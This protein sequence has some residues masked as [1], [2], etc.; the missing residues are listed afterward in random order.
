LYY[1]LKIEAD[2]YKS[3]KTLFDGI[4]I[5]EDEDSLAGFNSGGKEI[6]VENELNNGYEFIN[7]VEIS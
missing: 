5:R 1:S 7:G 6:L 2:R 3:G 4:S